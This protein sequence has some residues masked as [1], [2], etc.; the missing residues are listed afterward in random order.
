MCLA[1]IAAMCA[2]VYGFLKP[3]LSQQ[4]HFAQPTYAQI[5][6]PDCYNEAH[7][8]TA[9]SAVV[10]PRMLSHELVID[11]TGYILVGLAVHGVFFWTEQNS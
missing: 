11:G 4:D 9:Y 5:C 3:H 1:V 8:L 7:E 2:L 10:S 6:R